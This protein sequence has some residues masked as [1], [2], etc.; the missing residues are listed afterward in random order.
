METLLTIII[1]LYCIIVLF[2]IIEKRIG[3]L[4][5]SKAAS[6]YEGYDPTDQE[7]GWKWIDY[8]AGMKSSPFLDVYDRPD[9]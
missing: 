1:G 4:P 3:K 2:I 5:C 9:L 6:M 8:S 7:I